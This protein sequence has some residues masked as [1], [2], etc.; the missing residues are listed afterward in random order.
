MSQPEKI[1]HPHSMFTACCLHSLVGQSIKQCK[2]SRWSAREQDATQVDAKLIPWRDDTDLRHGGWVY[3]IFQHMTLEVWTDK[4]Q[5]QP[6][7]QGEAAQKNPR[8][9][10]FSPKT[11]SNLANFYPQINSR[12]Y[13]FIRYHRVP[14]YLVKLISPMQ[15]MVWVFTI[16]KIHNSSQVNMG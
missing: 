14:P 1:E 15:S 10:V 12:V 9:F 16:V 4:F 2:A 8:K 7:L 6:G 5:L 13:T 11:F 3:W